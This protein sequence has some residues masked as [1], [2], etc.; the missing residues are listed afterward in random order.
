[1]KISNRKII[2]DQDVLNE[3]S[4]LQLPVKVSYAISKNISKLNSELKTFYSQRQL[5]IDKYC[6]RDE[7]GN[8]IADDKGNIHIAAEHLETWGKEIEELLDI[9]NEVDIH[10]FKLECFENYNI[11]LT[12]SQMSAINYMIEM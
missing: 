7:E 11:K 2:L 8:K 4:Q 10:K 1:M 5:L 3:I 12:P 6:E 9:E